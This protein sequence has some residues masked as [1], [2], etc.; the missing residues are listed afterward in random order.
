MTENGTLTAVNSND[1]FVRNLAGAI[2]PDFILVDDN[3][4]PHRAYL[5]PE[6]IVRM[7]ENRTSIPII[8]PG[9]CY[10]DQFHLDLCS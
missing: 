6:T 1:Q 3:A 10:S 8:M 5:E 7:A 4:P 2:G 9:T